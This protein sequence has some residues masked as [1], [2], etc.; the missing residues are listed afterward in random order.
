MIRLRLPD[1]LLAF[2]SVPG[3]VRNSGFPPELIVSKRLKGAQ[4]DV[5]CGLSKPF[6]GSVLLAIFLLGG[7]ALA[8]A[9]APAPEQPPASSLTNAPALADPPLPPLG[10]AAPPEPTPIPLLRTSEMAFPAADT[11][12][13]NEPLVSIGRPVGHANYGEDGNRRAAQLR[14]MPPERFTFDRALLRDVLRFLAESA[15]IPYIGIP[16]HSLAAQRLVTF[17]MTASPFTALESLARQ[18]DIKIAYEDGVW[19]MRLRDANLERIR[20]TEDANELVGVIYHLKYDPA[21]RVDFRPNAMGGISGAAANSSGI[22]GNAAPTT[23]NMPL[24][25]SQRVFESKAPRIVNEIRIMVGLQPLQ[26][27][28]DGTV[29]DPDV[30]SSTEAQRA[31]LPSSDGVAA[32]QAAAG[33]GG[34]AAAAAAAGGTNAQGGSLLPVYVPPQRPQV[35]YNSDSNLLWVVATRKQQK[36]V[37]DYLVRVDKP[38]DL[39]AIEVKFF[40]TRKNPKTDFGINWE[41]TLGTGI[42]V[43]GS[44]SV[45]PSGNTTDR[46]TTTSTRQTGTDLADPANPIPPYDFSHTL[47]TAV[48][49]TAIP[50]S[51]VLSLDQVGVTLQAFAQDRDSS[52]VQYPRVLTINNREVAITASENT[53]VNAG[54]S[55]TQS[56]S[57]ATQTGTLGYLP[58]GTQINILPK[59]VGTGQIALTVAITISQIIRYEQINLGT[60]LN[61]YPVTTQRVYNAALQVD[62]GYTLAVG[63]LEKAS[64]RNSVGGVPILKDIPGLGYL[65]KNKSKERDKSNLII[66]ITP[67]LISDPSRTPGIS[68]TPDAVIP[69][70]PGVPPPAPNFT[71]D[72]GLLGGEA[73]VASALA[74]LEFQLQY[75]TQVNA[76]ARDDSRSIG[77]L[78]SVIERA[79]TLTQFL[80][81]QIGVSGDMAESSDEADSLL[82]SLNKILA[83]ALEDQFQIKQGFP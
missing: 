73:A 27:N 19:F 82:V 35:I 50:Y 59:K 38:Q 12:T 52:L 36:W 61:P 45:S 76:E 24:Q 46:S 68:E 2:R 75:F 58:T 65:F 70:R 29:T 6:A 26:Y 21:D 54:V 43:K 57:T 25:N 66:F 3:F 51:A 14:S 53:P 62:S 31:L 10:G 60:G 1:F 28:S 63:G 67:Y 42:T 80:Q 32:P 77:E 47:S 49:E 22:A 23:P 71:P 8:Q 79:R 5:L 44:A 11:R 83:K 17:K 33:G 72:G 78:R 16:E 20:K 41:N 9:P 56:G 40:E 74:W 13:E 18:N 30:R 64:D 48:T 55:Q 7:V 81:A 39:I 34:A 4:Q 37:A 15:G 69:I